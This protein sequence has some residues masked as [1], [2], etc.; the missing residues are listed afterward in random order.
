MADIYAIFGFMVLMGLSYPA[1]LTTWWL[2]F[3]ERV[4]RA[5]IRIIE[6]PKRVFG[7]GILYG[8]IAAIP[9]VILFSLPSQFTKVLGWLWLVVLLGVASLGSA[10]IAA[11]IGLRLNW[12]NDGVYQS[13]G[14]YL[15]GAVLWELAA[16]FPVIGWLLIIPLGTLIS[17]GGA[18]PIILKKK[19]VKEPAGDA[20]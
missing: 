15:R 10:G 9:M 16:V 8:L 1:L 18:V 11:E 20:D 17:I 19:S 4:E 2:I 7:M 12:K 3:P 5:R 6:R 13:L 14:A